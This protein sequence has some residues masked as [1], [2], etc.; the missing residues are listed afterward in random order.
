MK[1]VS[2]SVAV[3]VARKLGIPPAM[4]LR[5]YR[6]YWKFI[7]DTVSSLPEA[8]MEEG[9]GFNVPYIGKLYTNKDKIEK[10]LRKHK[11]YEE[12]VKDKENEAVVL[13]GSGD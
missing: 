6:S 7:H 11:Y 5:V 8:T 10:Y 1:S 2:S 12:N 13:P 9:F 3:K 4:A